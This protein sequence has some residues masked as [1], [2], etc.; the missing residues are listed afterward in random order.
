VRAL[1]TFTLSALLLG[2]AAPASGTFSIVAHDSVT[3]ELGV[4][5]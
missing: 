3:G 2:G 5:V 1:F 4:A